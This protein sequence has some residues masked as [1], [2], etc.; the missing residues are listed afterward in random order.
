MQKDGI[1]LYNSAKNCR[2]KGVIL[3]IGSW[4]GKSTVC[5]AKGSKKGKNTKVIAVDHH[6]GSEEHQKPEGVWTFDEFK[7][8]IKSAGIDDIVTPILKTSIDAS[9]NFNEPIELLF[10]DGAHD[11]DSVKADF[12]SWFPKVTKNGKILF[13]DSEWDGVRKYL[14]E[15]SDKKEKIVF[16]SYAGCITCVQKVEKLTDKDIFKN[17]MFVNLTNEIASVRKNTKN[18]N[19]L[20]ELQISITRSILKRFRALILCL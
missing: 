1:F 18:I 10:L 16:K 6:I 13:H 14:T 17:K 5:L 4:K 19:S 12:E 20:T 3:E 7:Q 11:Y 15:L 9:K 2:G 8:N